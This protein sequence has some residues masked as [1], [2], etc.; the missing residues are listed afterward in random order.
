ML[1]F[2]HAVRPLTLQRSPAQ[3]LLFKGLQNVP[4]DHSGESAQRDLVA[5]HICG[6]ASGQMILLLYHNVC[7]SRQPVAVET[8][9]VSLLVALFD[10]VAKRFE[11][12]HLSAR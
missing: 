9:A 7:S 1:H 3:C 11:H 5:G 2:P 4:S 12:K 10:E 6:Q 8:Q